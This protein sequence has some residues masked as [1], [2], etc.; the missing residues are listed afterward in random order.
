ME[1]YSKAETFLKYPF[2]IDH[3]VSAVSKWT[4]QERNIM[5]IDNDGFIHKKKDVNSC[6]E[7]LDNCVPTLHTNSAYKNIIRNF[8]PPETGVSVS[9]N[10][11]N[12]TIGQ[13]LDAREN[14]SLEDRESKACDVMVLDHGLDMAFRRQNDRKIRPYLIKTNLGDVIAPESDDRIQLAEVNYDVNQ[15]QDLDLSPHL[16]LYDPRMP[17]V[18]HHQVKGY[19]LMNLSGR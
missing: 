10:L 19:Y 12:L 4:P 2:D 13:I 18:G 5:K 17:R 3:G 9:D 8:P 7:I 11:R 16:N 14:D 1:A 15:Y 6:D